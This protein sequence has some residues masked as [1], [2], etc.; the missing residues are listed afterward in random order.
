MASL[1]T[2]SESHDLRP[3]L[4]DDLPLSN[5]L[6]QTVREFGER[7][8]IAVETSVQ[9]PVRRVPDA[10]A[11]AVFRLT[12]EALGN[13]ERHAGASQVHVNLAFNGRPAALHLEIRDNGTGFD[14][15]ALMRLPREGLGL[16]NMRERIEM[17]EGE[18]SVVSGP[19]GT[20]VSINIPAAALK[21]A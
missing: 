5:A 15:D 21:G 12:Q 17:L 20:T 9:T 3:T 2:L 14:V 1:T 6:E 4:L 16:T 19:R 7:S 11:T 18:F 8:G 13:I 10:V